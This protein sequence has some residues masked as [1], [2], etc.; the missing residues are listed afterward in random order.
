MQ[1]TSPARKIEEED[2]QA[3]AFV[4]AQENSIKHVFSNSSEDNRNH[5]QNSLIDND[6]LNND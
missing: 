5:Q 1:S 3:N 2:V 4:N 6:L